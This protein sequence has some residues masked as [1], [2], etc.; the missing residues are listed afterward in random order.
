MAYYPNYHKFYHYP[1]LICTVSLITKINTLI[2]LTLC[3]T[4]DSIISTPYRGRGQLK[5]IIILD[6]SIVLPNTQLAE[7]FA[8][9]YAECGM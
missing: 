4:I 9:H 7:E 1:T 2:K 8:S 6:I 3:I 5:N